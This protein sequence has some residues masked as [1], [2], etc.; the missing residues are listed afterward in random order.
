MYGD[1]L[2]GAQGEDVVAGTHGTEPISVLDD[3]MPDLAAR[4]KEYS[5]LLEHHYRDVCDIEF[6]IEDGRLWLLQ[7]RI[8]KRSPQAA[9]RIAIEMAEDPGFPLSRSEAVER[10]ARHLADP[11]TTAEDS[12]GDAEAITVALGASPGT[13][14]GRI[15]TS[16]EMAVEMSERGESVILVRPET[17]PDDVRGMTRAA[18]ILTSTGGLA[19]HAAVVAR[20]WGI[21]A[22]VG[23]SEVKVGDGTVEIAG[24]S[25]ST[26]DS[27]TIDGATGEVFA[28]A[29]A[30]RRHIVP[31]AATLLE[32]AEE[33]GIPITGE[34]AVAESRGTGEG[35]TPD[36]VV[37]A[38]FIKG[39]VMPDGAAPVLGCSEPEAVAAL[40]ALAGE[41]LAE[42]SGGMFQLT[43]AGKERGAELM[44]ADREAWG[45]D[46]AEAGLEGFLP[47]DARMKVVVTAWQMREEDGQPVVNDH[48]DEEYDA[49]VLADFARLAGEADEWIAPLCEELPRLAAYRT[50]LSD[51]AGRVAGGDPAYIASPRVDSYHNVWFELH[52]DLIHLAGR[53]REDE[54]AAG[55]A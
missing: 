53:T 1:I 42:E 55:R 24:R 17:S 44:A 25:F 2:F 15:A 29:L 37:R 16:P 35:P 39:F 46:R 54:V 22:V 47:L 18:G 21:P 52:E 34:E 6:T 45:Q 43:E 40:E 3:R 30:G 23:A 36:G 10:V 31:E 4:L 5:D 27:L 41:G 7:T 51:A 8:G 13:G 19:S 28:G 14:A 12:R 32:W 11:P 33:A 49:A 50:R 38:L 26:E 20:G 48:S 9:L